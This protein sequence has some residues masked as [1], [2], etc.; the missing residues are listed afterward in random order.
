MPSRLTVAASSR[1][2]D[3]HRIEHRARR[4]PARPGFELAIRLA[5]LAREQA[6]RPAAAAKADAIGFEQDDLHAGRRAG[7]G[8][9]GAGHA[10]ANDH[11]RMVDDA[12][13]RGKLA[14]LL[15]RDGIQPWGDAVTS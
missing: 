15:Y 4:A 1:G 6:G 12:A 14:P 3:L 7:I 2:A 11:D 13:K 9:H 5:G 8:G 10:A